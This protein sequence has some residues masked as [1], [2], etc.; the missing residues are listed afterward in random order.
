VRRCRS[1]A[2]PRPSIF[3]AWRIR[4]QSGG[5]AKTGARTRNSARGS[6]PRCAPPGARIVLPPSREPIPP[7]SGTG[8]N[9][10]ESGLERTHPRAP[11][12]RRGIPTTTAIRWS[13]D[14]GADRRPATRDGGKVVITAIRETVRFPHSRKGRRVRIHDTRPIGCA[15]TN[16]AR[17]RNTLPPSLASYACLA[18]KSI[19]NTKNFIRC[20]RGGRCIVAPRRRTLGRFFREGLGVCIRGGEAGSEQT[21]FAAHMRSARPRCPSTRL[22]CG[23]R[24]AATCSCGPHC[25]Y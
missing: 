15:H 12:S 5:T 22:P 23:S 4:N 7:A 24:T 21:G 10:A 6:H 14:S 25:D 17:R 19:I 13:G 16:T 11:P 3:F 20:Y 8:P 2:H 18:N 1:D 9:G